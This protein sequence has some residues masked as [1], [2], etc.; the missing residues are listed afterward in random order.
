MIHLCKMRSYF[1]WINSS[2]KVIIFSVHW[3]L[4]DPLLLGK[5][6]IRN[7]YRNPFDQDVEVYG[8]AALYSTLH[9]SLVG[10]KKL[11]MPKSSSFHICKAS[12]ESM[13]RLQT[14]FY[15]KNSHQNNL[16][17]DRMGRGFSEWVADQKSAGAT[18]QAHQSS[19]SVSL[20]EQ[21]SAT[22]TVFIGTFMP[23]CMGIVLIIRIH[24]KPRFGWKLVAHWFSMFPSSLWLQGWWC[25]QQQLPSTFFGG[26]QLLGGVVNLK[27]GSTCGGCVH[28]S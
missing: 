6:W 3:T 18:A 24:I 17:G 19:L 14:L 10:F 11:N 2:Y 28:K 25:Q 20:F 27:K 22:F 4:A 21:I 26:Q 12:L 23:S 7:R 15:W 13:R 1:F 8:L 16:P 5:A 9:R